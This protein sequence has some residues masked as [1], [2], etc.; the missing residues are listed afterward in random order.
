MNNEIATTPYTYPLVSDLKES[1]QL[2][3]QHLTS[4][5]SSRPKST[6][7]TTRIYEPKPEPYRWRKFKSD[8]PANYNVNF[9]QQSSD[10]WKLFA[11]EGDG[12]TSSAVP[13]SYSEAEAV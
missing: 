12:A 8:E 7:I 6:L 1:K 13:N 5:S 9:K 10:H 2:A 4:F 11:P 3:S